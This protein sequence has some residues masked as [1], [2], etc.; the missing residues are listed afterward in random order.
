MKPFLYHSFVS[1]VLIVALGGCFQSD[2]PK[3]SDI[4]VKTVVKNVY[5]KQISSLA[6]ENPMAAIFADALP[7]KIVRIDSARPLK[8]EEN[9]KLRT[10]KG[11]AYFDDNRSADIEYTVQLDEKNSDKFYVELKMDFLEDVAKEG[12]L[13]HMFKK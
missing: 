11:V 8:Y 10:C 4:K 6:N 3:C 12:I 9:I 13:Q 5:A 7:K 1:G 2:A